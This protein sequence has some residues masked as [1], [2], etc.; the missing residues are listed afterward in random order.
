[1]TDKQEIALTRQMIK[2]LKKGYGK[3]CE[4][5][6]IKDWRANF[7]KAEDFFRESRCAVCR[8]WEVIDWLEGHIK[9]IKY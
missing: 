9:L 4:T 3:R 1:M 7:K 5:S 2:V 6:D 8:A